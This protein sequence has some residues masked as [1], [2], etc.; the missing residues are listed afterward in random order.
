MT[1]TA[2]PIAT[3]ILKTY[4]TAFGTLDHRLFFSMI[5]KNP[6]NIAANIHMINEKVPLPTIYTATEYS[7][8]RIANSA[9]TSLSLR[10]T[11]TPFA[12]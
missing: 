10:I 9:Y 7:N 5:Y 4:L 11:Y 2:N 12:L 1:K 8:E 3:I 6:K